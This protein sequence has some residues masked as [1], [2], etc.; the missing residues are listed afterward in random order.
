MR[1]S[2]QDHAGLRGAQPYLDVGHEDHEQ[3]TNDQQDASA[4]P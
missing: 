3:K 4:D 2:A 1:V